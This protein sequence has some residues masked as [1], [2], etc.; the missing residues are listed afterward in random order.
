MTPGAPALPPE[1]D[2]EVLVVAFH[3]PGLLDGCLAALQGRL[4]VVVVDNSSDPAVR[5]VALRHGA[6]YH[7]PGSNLGFAAA[8]NTGRN[9]LHRPGADLLLLNPDAVISPGGV[10]RLRA[11]LHRTPRRAC[12]APAQTDPV[13]HQ[14][15]RVAWP[16]P[17][18]LGA[19]AESLG[20]GR[21]RRGG[22]FVI[23]SVLLVNAAALDEVGGFDERF[24]LYAEETDWQF[25]ADRLGW[26]NVLCPGVVASHVGAG[27]GGDRGEREVRFHAS[28][29]RYVRKHYGSRG[30][31]VFRSGVM[32]GAL[33]RALVLG[34][35]GGRRAAA[36]LRL[37]GAGPCRVEAAMAATVR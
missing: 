26:E 7:D 2:V 17:T 21:L 24:F 11:C 29:E 23:G 18:P 31:L 35:E 12:A 25:R 32:V 4:P 10:A 9:L 8:V 1:G 3:A 13:R 6:Q 28:T 14:S 22:Q 16:F 15:A 20:L 27:T 33:G 36:R 34:G 30:W 37:Y 19:W 5:A